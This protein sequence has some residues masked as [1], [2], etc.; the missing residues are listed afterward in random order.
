MDSTAVSTC[1]VVPDAYH[2]PR[3]GARPCWRPTRPCS[4]DL[5]RLLSVVIVRLRSSWCPA[6]PSVK[7]D[8]CQETS[9]LVPGRNT[10]R[11]I[12]RERVTVHRDDP[13]RSPFPLI[14]LPGPKGTP[15]VDDFDGVAVVT[16]IE[17]THLPALTAH[18][19]TCAA[20]AFWHAQ[21]EPK[22]C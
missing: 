5:A 17:A 16:W 6:Q 19:A 15:T 18:I 11:L 4:R 3:Q 12:P 21:C 2:G 7:E 9:L 1:L 13:A 20:S 10:A 22:G 8:D 14:L